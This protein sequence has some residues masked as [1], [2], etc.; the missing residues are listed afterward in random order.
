MKR[1]SDDDTYENDQKL[2]GESHLL[3]QANKAAAFIESIVPH[4]SALI[5]E[6]TREGIPDQFD[7]FNKD[8]D[9][10]PEPETQSPVNQTLGS[11]PITSLAATSIQRHVPGNRKSL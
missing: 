9:N 4:K 8:G 11:T 2:L 6:G 3:L 1:R 7:R 5:L 10:A